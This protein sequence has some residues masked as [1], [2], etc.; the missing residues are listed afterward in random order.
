MTASARGLFR[1]TG[2]KP[3]TVKALLDGQVVE[4][5]GLAREKNDFYPTP[6]EPTRAFLNAEL[7]RLRDFPSIWEP[8]AGDGAMVRELESL[9]FRVHASDLIDR[10][11]DAEIRSFYDYSEAPCP[12]IFTN[13]PYQE[14]G[15]GNGKARWL[16]HALDTLNVEYMAL[17]LN[18]NW[19][20]AAGLG[21]FWQR[22]PPARV[23][24]MRWK[25]DFTGQGAPPML[26]G[27]FVWDKAARG[28]TVLRTLDRKDARQGELFSEARK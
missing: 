5:A 8:A 24:I 11:C 17:L 9:G 2:K 22:F 27:W 1:A 10:G 16:F 13:P 3:K 19:P 28:E 7:Q 15:W 18:W 12:A 21:P 26:N 25:I 20:G 6:A 4:T 23:Y 14:C